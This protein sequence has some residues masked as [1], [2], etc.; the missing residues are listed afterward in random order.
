MDN[1]TL[2]RASRKISYLLRHNPGE[3]NLQMDKSG[4]VSVQELLTGLAKGACPISREELEQVVA[5]NDKKR[6]SFNEDGTKI[7]A[8]QGHSINVDLELPPQVPPDVLFHGTAKKNLDSIFGKGLQKRNRQHVH[9][10]SDE[11]TAKKVGSR[12]GSPI[13]LK[14]DAKTMHEH[15]I[16]FYISDNGVWLCESISPEYISFQ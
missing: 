2:T 4:W 8:N 1:R 11:E 9:L 7:R 14:I 10:S 12:H 6:F 15:G 3:L 13:V 16:P 5:E